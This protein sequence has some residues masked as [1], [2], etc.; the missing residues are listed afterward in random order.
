M[1]DDDWH[2]TVVPAEFFD[3]FEA[4]PYVRNEPAVRAA[5][6][7]RELL[8]DLVPDDRMPG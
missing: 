3:Q 7:W 4:A 6:R 2:Q 1:T 5:R 8:G